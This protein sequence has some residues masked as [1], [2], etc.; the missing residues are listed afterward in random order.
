MDHST[1]FSCHFHQVASCCF[2]AYF[3]FLDDFFSQRGYPFLGTNR[4]PVQAKERQ[5]II[6]KFYCETHDKRH[7]SNPLSRASRI[8][9]DKVL[10]VSRP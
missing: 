4:L 6:I 1:S 2:R 5:T 8:G 9:G 10:E 3:L 7:Y